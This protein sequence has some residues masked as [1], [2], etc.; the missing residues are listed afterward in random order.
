MPIKNSD[1]R[2]LIRKRRYDVNLGEK[3]LK[4]GDG[5][6]YFMIVCVV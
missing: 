2:R 5:R 4:V 1:L 3:T 6:N